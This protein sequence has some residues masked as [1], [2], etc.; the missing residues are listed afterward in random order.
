MC[1]IVTLT[2]NPSLD[3]STQ[4]TQVTA[5][6]KLRC[7]TPLYEPGGGGINVSR[8]IRRLGGD[9]LALYPSGGIFGRLLQDLLGKEGIRHHPIGIGGETRENFTVLEE[10]SG[11]QYRFGMPGPT[12]KEEEWKKCLWRLS[13][14]KSQ[15]RFLVASGSLPPGVP[16]DFYAQVASAAT[17]LGVRLVLDTSKRAL[18]QGIQKGGV[19]LVKPNLRELRDLAGEGIEHES[20]LAE[21]A[22]ELIRK[23]QTEVVVVSLG[24][25]GVFF[26]SQEG[27]GRLR[28]PTVPIQSKVGAGDSMLAGLVLSLCRGNSVGESV[29]FGVA[30]GAAAVMTP[31]TELCR[32]EDTERLY[33]AMRQDKQNFGQGVQS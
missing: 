16:D 5:E 23:N 11:V 18:Q 2:M 4:V 7:H 20:R 26:A 24:A 13:S 17:A 30:A 19:F 8:A 12:L 6:R 32:R 9:S 25:A 27:T 21:I 28:A 22:Q 3:V 33:L 10:S 29:R 14:L 1:E 31:G 15:A